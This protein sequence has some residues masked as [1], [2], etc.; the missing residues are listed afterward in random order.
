MHVVHVHVHDLNYYRESSGSIKMLEPFSAHFARFCENSTH[1]H[2]Y[3][4]MFM[5][6]MWLWWVVIML[7]WATKSKRLRIKSRPP[8]N[9]STNIY[10]HIHFC[11][12]HLS[13]I[14]WQCGV[15]SFVD[16]QLWSACCKHAYMH[17]HRIK[18]HTNTKIHTDADKHAYC[19]LSRTHTN[20]FVRA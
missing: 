13:Q 20:Q 5:M 19:T 10:L 8:S 7:E 14:K 6:K 15:G 12:G 1:T 3:C 11:M 9:H 2:T 18:N 16:R 4:E 17:N